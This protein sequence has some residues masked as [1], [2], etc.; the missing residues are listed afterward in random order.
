MRGAGEGIGVE[1]AGGRAL[2]DRP[3]VLG[4]IVFELDL[5]LLTG[6]IHI[7]VLGLTVFDGLLHALFEVLGDDR[8]ADL[9]LDDKAADVSDLLA[10]QHDAVFIKRIGLAAGRKLR[11]AVS[12][13][14]EG[15]EAEVEAE[16]L[17]GVVRADDVLIGNGKESAAARDGVE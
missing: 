3:L 14:L 9:G 6:V 2:L 7:G 17:A 16:L 1:H 8:A 4:G 5:A 10:I 11:F 13:R 12:V 15:V